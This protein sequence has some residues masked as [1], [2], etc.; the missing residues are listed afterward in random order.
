MNR[1]HSLATLLL[2][3]LLCPVLADERQQLGKPPTPPNDLDLV[4][5][6]RE[7][8]KQYQKSLET[9]REHYQKNGDLER[10]RWC[11]EELMSF[12]R[13]SKREYRLDLDVPPPTLQAAYNIPEANELF[14]KAMSFKGKGWFGEGDDNVRRAELLFQ[15]LL[16]TYPQSDKIDKSA[17][18]LGEIYESRVFK[19]Y[20]RAALYYE[21]VCDWNPNTDSDACMRAARLYDK[22]LNDRSKA[23][24]LYRH[25]VT[26][27]GD[28]K[29]VD[30]A[31][32][33]LADLSA[34]PP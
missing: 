9:L 1:R 33:R 20:R 5:R 31:K 34:A 3:A 24:Q 6:V 12:H 2:T 11:E 8:R 13:I 21:R 26:H 25:I 22:Q 29:R 7:S 16:E 14:R 15:K 30:E 19:Q 28:A 27:S 17:Y 23:I 32:R 10:M 4:Q 18:A